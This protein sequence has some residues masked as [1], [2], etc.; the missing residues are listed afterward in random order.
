VPW[1]WLEPE[2]RKVAKAESKPIER[3]ERWRVAVERY[4]EIDE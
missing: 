1:V 3:N 4:P 2:Q